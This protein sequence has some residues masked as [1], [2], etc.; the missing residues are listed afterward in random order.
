[1][2][3][4]YNVN[5]SLI[6]EMRMLAQHALGRGGVT[7]GMPTQ[8]TQKLLC[9]PCLKKRNNK[10]KAVTIAGGNAVCQEHLAQ[11]S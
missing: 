5:A 6:H 8:E 3:R 1:M 10:R 7:L 9:A 4:S 11:V 2:A